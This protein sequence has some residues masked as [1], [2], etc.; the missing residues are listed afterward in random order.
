MEMLPAM[1]QSW[2]QTNIAQFIAPAMAQFVSTPLHLVGLDLYNRPGV[3]WTE[4]LGLLKR[5]YVTSSFARIMR[6]VPAFGVGG[7]VNTNVR[8]SLMAKY[9]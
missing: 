8:E 4:R 1:C 9:E 2:K 3:G 7:V 6:I 5:A